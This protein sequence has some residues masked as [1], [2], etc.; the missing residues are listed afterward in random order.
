MWVH[1]FFYQY[2]M[3]NIYQARMCNK[4]FCGMIATIKKDWM[5]AHM[6]DDLLTW[7]NKFDGDTFNRHNAKLK[8][9]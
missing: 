2:Y 8:M 1:N 3:K 7:L 9:D 4:I 6:I 5:I